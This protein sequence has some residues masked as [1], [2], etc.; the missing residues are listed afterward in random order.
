MLPRQMSSAPSESKGGGSVSVNVVGSTGRLTVER[1]DTH[2]ERV[3]IRRVRGFVR[4]REG[5]RGLC[6]GAGR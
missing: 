1:H 5:V 3:L 4:M 6:L 2:L